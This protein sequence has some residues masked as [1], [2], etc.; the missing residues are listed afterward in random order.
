MHADG[1]PAASVTAAACLPLKRRT[2]GNGL[3]GRRR[4]NG[5][6]V[7]GTAGVNVRRSDSVNV[8]TKGDGLSKSGD[9]NL[10]RNCKVFCVR[11]RRRSDGLRLNG[12]VGNANA[13]PSRK[14]SATKYLLW[15]SLHGAI[16]LRRVQSSES[17]E[18]FGLASAG[19]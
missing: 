3:N 4:N 1:S 14:P 12:G 10:R 17:P 7:S 19:L 8:R 2:N 15:C 13:K 5:L 6:S 18:C 16:L 9:G 11:R